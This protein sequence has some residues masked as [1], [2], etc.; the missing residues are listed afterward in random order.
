MLTAEENE[1]V[2]RLAKVMNEDGTD[3]GMNGR[4]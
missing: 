3:L 2:S 4:I 1:S